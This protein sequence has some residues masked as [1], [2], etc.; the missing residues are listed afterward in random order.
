MVRRLGRMMRRHPV[1]AYVLLAYALSWSIGG[2]LALQAQGAL[3]ELLPY[4]LHY[5]FSFGPLGAAV[6][7]TALQGGRRDVQRLFAGLT[8]RAAQAAP[9]LLAVGVP[10]AAFGVA[11]AAGWILTGHAPE[12]AR[13]GAVDYLPRLGWAGALAVWIA[14]YG[15]GEELGWR[16]FALPLLQ[17]RHG[18]LGGTRR[19]AL[20]WVFWHLPAFFYREGYQAMGLLFG[21]ALLLATMIPGAMAFTWL[22]NLARGH[23]LAVVLL[24][25]LY[26]YFAVS[27]AAGDLT[28]PVMTMALVCWGLWAIVQYRR[29]GA[30]APPAVTAPWA[31]SGV[32]EGG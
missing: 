29:A 27:E 5:L 23:L 10:L 18:P 12:L 26:D 1:A 8:P 4:A 30:Q 21:L 11:C 28:P 24:H 14:T 31:H 19:L 25:G 20:A 32:S 6:V 22:Y 7:M 2:P 15:V 13:L 16:G 3:P 17:Q 9:L